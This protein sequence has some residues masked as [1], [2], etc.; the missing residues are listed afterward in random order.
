MKEP[1]LGFAAKYPFTEEAKKYVEYLGLTL[2]EILKHPV[3]GECLTAGK[4]RFL[5]S[6]KGGI[7]ADVSDKIN[8]EITILSYPIA[9][10]IANAVDI[11]HIKARYAQSEAESAY[12]FFRQDKKDLEKIMKELGAERTREITCSEY[13][14][15]TQRLVKKEARW[16]LVNRVMSGGKIGLS[17]EEVTELLRERIMLKVSEPVDVRR[18]P[19]RVL[20]E[21]SRVADSLK[22]GMRSVELDELDEK[23]L[24][25]CIMGLIGSLEAGAMSHNMMFIL[26]TFL[27][28]LGLSED[29]IVEVFS[30]SPSFDERKTRY[31]LKFLSGERGHTKYSCPTCSKIKSYGM[32]REECG[33]SHP[34]QY[35]RRKTT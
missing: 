6:L 18:A 9:R 2:S 23:T 26:G 16:K 33:V 28:G 30:K 13:L 5:D 17:E 19:S 10:L 21:A 14:R 20:E 34:L 29:Q 11:S 1:D 7:N 4:I 15:L 31:Q 3:Y 12:E 22:L 25:P 8:Q 32:C 24:P 35:V 27:N